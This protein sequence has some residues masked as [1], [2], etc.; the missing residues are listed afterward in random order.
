M[1]VLNRKLKAG[2]AKGM[3]QCNSTAID[4]HFAGLRFASLITA[5]AWL[6]K[7]SFN[8]MRSIS[9]RFMP[10]CFNTLGIAATGPI[11]MMRR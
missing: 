9:A 4:I 7:A 8:S 5:S 6:A 11:P 2:A 3:T 10:A 1:E